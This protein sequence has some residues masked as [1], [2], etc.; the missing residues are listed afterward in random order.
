MSWFMASISTM[1]SVAPSVEALNV[2]VSSG[3]VPSGICH[4]AICHSVI[5][6][7]SPQHRSWYLTV[8]TN[9]SIIPGAAMRNKCG[10]VSGLWKKTHSTVKKSREKDQPHR[11][12]VDLEVDLSRDSNDRQTEKERQWQ[13]DT[14]TQRQAVRQR[15]TEMKRER[16]MDRQCR[17]RINRGGQKEVDRQR[18]QRG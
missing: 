8:T 12:G 1:S 6:H 13:T 7:W 11:C 18:R 5:C 16:Q 2:A 9:A 10:S 14:V 15:K 17:E 3:M 4:G